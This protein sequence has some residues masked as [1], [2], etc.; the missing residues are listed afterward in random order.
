M[1]ATVDKGSTSRAPHAL[2]TVARILLVVAIPVLLLVSPVYLIASPAY[3][4]HEYG[5]RNFPLSMRF[6]AAERLRLSSTIVKYVMGRA[7]EQE[8]ATLRTDAGETALRDEEVQHLIDVRVVMDGFR[9]AHAILLLLAVLSLVL[10]WHS[11]RRVMLPL[12]LRQGVWIAAG[13]I[14]FIVLASVLN[15]DVFFTRFHQIFFSEGSWLFF[16]DDTLIQLYPLPL[17]VDAVWKIGVLV[18]VEM[19]LLY[20]LAAWVRGAAMA[21]R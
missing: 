4:R 13:V 8:M 19:A 5:L 7:T 2:A 17:W 14:F 10:L 12:Y 15:F 20:A 18:A 1:G 9:L 6:S 11:A 21:G 16:E 3:M